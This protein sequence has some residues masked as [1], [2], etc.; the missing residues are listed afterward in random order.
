MG[1]ITTT[2]AS[3][4]VDLGGPT[5]R[6]MQVYFINEMEKEPKFFAMG[7]R[8]EAEKYIP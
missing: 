7:T 2:I 6:I 8:K 3:K 1:E 4:I 5:F